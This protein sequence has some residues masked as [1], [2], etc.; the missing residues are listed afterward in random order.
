MYNSEKQ[1]TENCN[2]LQK[3]AR[4]CLNIIP[5]KKAFLVLFFIVNLLQKIILIY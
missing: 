5:Q 2:I 4:W 3:I 1:R